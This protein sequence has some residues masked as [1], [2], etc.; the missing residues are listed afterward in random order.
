M[1]WPERPADLDKP[2]HI[3]RG[4][5]W[6]ALLDRLQLLSPVISAYKANDTT[7]SNA[8]TGA[9]YTADP[10]LTVTVEANG[11]YAYHLHTTLTANVTPQLKARFGSPSGSALAAAAYHLSTAFST[12]G[13]PTTISEVTGITAAAG[14]PFA[15]H[16]TLFVGATGG[17]FYLDWAQTTAN[18]TGVT[19]HKGSRL[20]VTKMN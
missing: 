18:A 14:T 6:E 13:S 11:I 12:P 16:G 4:D 1:A 19:V 15:M 17:A 7:R 20:I 8:G 2:G 5:E 10:D 3:P 9:T